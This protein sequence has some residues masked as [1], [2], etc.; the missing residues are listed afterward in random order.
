MSL[1][2]KLTK[3]FLQDLNKEGRKEFS[4]QTSDDDEVQFIPVPDKVFEGVCSN[5]NY[6]FSLVSICVISISRNIKDK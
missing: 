6:K 1:Q 3:T 5:I 2:L 4:C